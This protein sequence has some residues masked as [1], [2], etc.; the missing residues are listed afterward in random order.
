MPWTSVLFVGNRAQQV[1]E[2]DGIVTPLGREPEGAL[3]RLE[4][5]RRERDGGLGHRFRCGDLDAVICDVRY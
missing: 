4:R 3:N 2:G 5:L 1:L